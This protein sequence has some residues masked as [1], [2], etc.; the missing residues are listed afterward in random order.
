MNLKLQ[1]II[2]VL[3]LAALCVLINMIRKRALELRYALAWLLVAVAV[4]I[5]DIFPAVME[6]LA[7]L[8]G[9]ASAMNMLFFA[10]FCFALLLIFI[11]TVTVSQMTVQIKNLTQQ[12]ALM[13]KRLKEDE[14]KYEE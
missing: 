2:A 4:L 10:G 11:L 6:K 14:K 5:L 7:D 3:L 8:V 12:M 13:E 9:I 1:I